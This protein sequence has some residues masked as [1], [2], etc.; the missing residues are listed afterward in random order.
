MFQP[1][2]VRTPQ[3]FQVQNHR[4][5][6]EKLVECL[7]MRLP[8]QKYTLHRSGVGRQVSGTHLCGNLGQFIDRDGLGL[9]QDVSGQC[10]FE[11][12]VNA[13]AEDTWRDLCSRTEG[14]VSRAIVC[15][16]LRSEVPYN[17]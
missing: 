4:P 5:G 12:N 8:S 6:G 2:C 16:E 10:R 11:I 13:L 15:V 7:K 17:C 9:G 14:A 3:L 1:G